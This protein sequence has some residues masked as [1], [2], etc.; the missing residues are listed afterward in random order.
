MPSGHVN[1]NTSNIDVSA[2]N[3]VLTRVTRGA[4]E[5]RLG[6]QDCLYASREILPQL[7]SS[8]TV[9]KVLEIA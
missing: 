4:I 5:V 2:S 1:Q 6:R 8:F 3:S 9:V 7:L